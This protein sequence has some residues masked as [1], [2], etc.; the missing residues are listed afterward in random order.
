MKRLSKVFENI[1]GS[2]G[3]EYELSKD[4]TYYIVS[5]I[6]T[7][8][9]ADIVIPTKYDRKRVADIHDYAFDDCV[10]IES[11]AIPGRVSNIG[12]YAFSGCSSLKSVMFEEGGKLSGIGVGAFEN[13]TSLANITIPNS[14][15][16][17]YGWAFA[18]CESLESITIPSSVQ[19]IGEGAF[20]DCINLE[21]V[22]F[23]GT[24]EQ[25]AEIQIDSNNECLTDAN[26]VFD[27]AEEEN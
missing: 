7:C 2:S 6:G 12:W 25:W 15:K 23:I 5:G 13:C 10:N 16:N 3:L 20:S 27:Y 19:W 24:E 17:I 18:G 26:I 8:R 21:T 4:K 1:T 14:V 22:H 11:I 9:D